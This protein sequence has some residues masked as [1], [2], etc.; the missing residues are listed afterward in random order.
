MEAEKK[1][2]ILHFNDVYDISEGKDHV[3]GGIA[4]FAAAMQAQKTKEPNTVVLFSG[5]LWSPS[6]RKFSVKWVLLGD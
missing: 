5:D 1:L 4:R 6:R 3:C 2:T